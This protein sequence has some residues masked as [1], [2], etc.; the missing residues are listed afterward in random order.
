MTEPLSSNSTQP[1]GIAGRLSIL[2]RFLPLWIFLAMAIGIGLGAVIPHIKDAFSALSIGTVSLPI[3]VG[4]IWMM[5]P[6]LAK[7]KYE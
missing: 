1:T 7:V 2:D 5:Y 4:L 6:V 3:A